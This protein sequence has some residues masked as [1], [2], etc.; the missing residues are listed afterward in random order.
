M[1]YVINWARANVADSSPVLRTT[2]LLCWYPPPAAYVKV[3]TDVSC[4]SNARLSAGG[5]VRNTQG[6]RL[7][8]FPKAIGRGPIIAAELWGV[9]DGLKLA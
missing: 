8:G 4:G 3:N 7:V 2:L 9:Y 1:R 6:N 5:L